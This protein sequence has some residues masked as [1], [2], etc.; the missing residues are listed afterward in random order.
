MQ[1]SF[2]PKADA[3]Y[4]QIRPGVVA[5]TITVHDESILLDVDEYGW[6]LGIEVIKPTPDLLRTLAQVKETHRIIPKVKLPPRG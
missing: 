2:D 3:V 5:K 4:L 6:V 1:Y